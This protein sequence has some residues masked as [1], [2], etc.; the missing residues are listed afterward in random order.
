MSKD[1]YATL[2]VDKTASKDEVKRAFRRLAHE[3][4]PDKGGDEAKFKEINEAYHILHDDEKRAQ[5]DQF[6]TTFDGAGGFPGGG[7]SGQGVNFEDLGDIFG[8][9]FGGGFGGGGG[10]S[11]RA[12]GADIAV[13][14]KL[15]FKESVFGV[16]KELQVSKNSDCERCGGVGAE[17][18]TN[19]KTCDACKGSGMETVVQRTMFGTMQRQTACTACQG[20]GEDPETKC[21]TC[22]GIGLEYGRST[23]RVEIPAGIENGMQIRVRGQGEAIGASGNAGDLYLRV[24]VDV[25]PRFRREG[26][27]IYVDKKIGFTQAALGDEVEV[28]TVDGKVKL[29]IPAG[30]QA[31]DKLKLRGKGVQT[32][33]GRGDQIVIVQVVT[34]TRLGRKEKKLVE[35]LDLREK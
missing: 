13:D 14:V 5:Y 2:G 25:D 12:R 29:K 16:E 28:D 23:I 3:H 34:P 18:G 30:T 26:N 8:D 6:G 19:M 35:E 21:S 7:F 17:P 22:H 32:A 4:H 31:G 15:S 1:Y 33:R 20:R 9:I 11:R 24:H 27:N 10:R